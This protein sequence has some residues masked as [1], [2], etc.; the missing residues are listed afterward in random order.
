MC[1]RDGKPFSLCRVHQLATDIRLRYLDVLY[2]L[3]RTGQDILLENDKIG[4]FAGLQRAL[5]FLGKHQESIVDRVEANRLLAGDP[6][7]R[8]EWLFGP[9]RLS[10]ERHPHSVEGGVWVDGL[11]TADF[12]QMG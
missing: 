2:L 1:S 5:L 4:Q 9:A 12:L 6:F 11:H 3:N 7:F 8:V 10:Y